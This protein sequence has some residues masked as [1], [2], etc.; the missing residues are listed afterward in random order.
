MQVGWSPTFISKLGLENIDFRL[1][2]GG[3]KTIEPGRKLEISTRTKTNLN[4]STW[5]M[6]QHG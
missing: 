1:F 6:L 3:S 4:P 5:M 2:R